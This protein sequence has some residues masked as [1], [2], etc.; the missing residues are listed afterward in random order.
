[1][2]LQKKSKGQKKW[3]DKDLWEL[4]ECAKKKV[5]WD[6]RLILPHKSMLRTSESQSKIQQAW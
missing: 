3:E 6:T 4:V 2:R 1:M 5:Q